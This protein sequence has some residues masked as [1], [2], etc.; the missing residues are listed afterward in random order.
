MIV[1]TKPRWLVIGATIR[2]APA[3]PARNLENIA[4]RSLRRT[5]ITNIIMERNIIDFKIY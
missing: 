3:I 4:R 1:V 5:L 2:K